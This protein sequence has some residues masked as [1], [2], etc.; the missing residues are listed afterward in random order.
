MWHSC[1]RVSVRDHLKGRPREIVRLYRQVATVVRSCGPGVRNVSS[2]TKT[3][4]MVRARFAGVEFRRDHLI[5][6][7]WLKREISSQRLRPAYYGRSD[8]GYTLPI[9]TPSDLDD[10]L[11][12]WLCEAYLVGRQEWKPD[13]GIGEHRMRKGPPPREAP[14]R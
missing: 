14:P 6:S 7:F 2:K 4:W 8:W 9:R 11:R 1:V 3:G 5:L 12:A 13:A 10:E